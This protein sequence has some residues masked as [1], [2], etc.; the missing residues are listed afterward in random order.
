MILDGWVLNRA[1]WGTRGLITWEYELRWGIY[2]YTVDIEVDS[3]SC[4]STQIQLQP[5]RDEF[6]DYYC[7]VR[8]CHH[9]HHHRRV[10]THQRQRRV[11]AQKH[12]AAS[13]VTVPRTCSP[14]TRTTRT[15]GLEVVVAEVASVAVVAASSTSHG[16][17][18]ISSRV[19]VAVTT[20]TFTSARLIGFLDTTR[21]F[22]VPAVNSLSLNHC[23]LVLRKLWGTFF[24]RMLFYF[25]EVPPG[26]VSCSNF[27]VAMTSK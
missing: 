1:S 25:M 2:I 16:R 12:R 4:A 5:R 27:E 10:Q 23:D 19:S 26:N 6:I 24:I 17:G 21:S 13:L 7:R 9:C 8:Y 14:R 20:G 22:V 18:W 15:M 11:W 3:H